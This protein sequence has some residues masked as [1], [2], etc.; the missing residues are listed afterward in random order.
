[1]QELG[2]E[3]LDALFP[4]DQ[5]RPVGVQLPCGLL[6]DL[7]I[8]VDKAQPVGEPLGQVGSSAAQL[9]GDGDMKRPTVSHDAPLQKL[10]TGLP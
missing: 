1:L 2:P 10:K 9:A 3:A 6:Q 5:F 4:P 7:V 8:Q